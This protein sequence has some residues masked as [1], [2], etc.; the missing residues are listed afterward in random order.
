MLFLGLLQF[1]LLLLCLV[2]IF[3]LLFFLF[4]LK[5]RWVKLIFLCFL[6]RISKL[7]FWF[8]HFCFLI[9]LAYFPWLLIWWLFFPKT[10]NTPNVLFFQFA[11]QLSQLLLSLMETSLRNH[12]LLC[13]WRWSSS[14]NRRIGTICSLFHF[15]FIFVYLLNS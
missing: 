8:I 11:F 9:Q 14:F 4:K 15:H 2:L 6:L 5:R 7:F 3:Y 10:I 1:D 13:L 12:W